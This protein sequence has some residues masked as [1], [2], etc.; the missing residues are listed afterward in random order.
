MFVS[1][2]G[3]TSHD[4]PE[5]S[6]STFGI[7]I[8]SENREINFVVLLVPDSGTDSD[9][10]IRSTAIAVAREMGMDGTLLEWPVDTT[11]LLTVDYECDYGTALEENTFEALEHTDWLV[12]MLERFD[13]PLTCFVQTEV[14]NEKPERVEELRSADVPV[15]FHPHSHTHRSRN[16]S[17]LDF[18]IRKSTS[19]YQDFFGSKPSGYRFPNGNVRPIDYERL[20]EYE[21][22][23]DASVFPSWRP[24]HF[25]NRNAVTRPQYFGEYDLFEIPFTVY[26]ETIRVPT[27]LSYCRLIGRPFTELLVRRPPSVVIFNIHMHDLVNPP[28]FEELSRFYRA[29]Y[30]RNAPGKPH[31]E[32]VL[33]KF[34]DIGLSFGQIDDIHVALE[35]G[36]GDDRELL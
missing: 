3:G 9:S 6:S 28:A 35:A 25:D 21:Y 5:K 27:A 22:E 13:V 15:S 2:N 4:P 18:E 20:A 32:T 24:G 17:D 7:A 8:A 10:L 11:V 29:V 31:L 19:D 1:V 30:S 34:R 33:T 16:E 14:L 36:R 26:S 12:S 23:F